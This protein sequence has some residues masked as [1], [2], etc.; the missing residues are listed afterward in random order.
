MV[1]KSGSF[2][3]FFMPTSFLSWNGP[4]KKNGLHHPNAECRRKWMKRLIGSEGS[5]LPSRIISPSLTARVRKQIYYLPLISRAET[6]VFWVEPPQLNQCH[7]YSCHSQIT[8][9]LQ[10]KDLLGAETLKHLRITCFSHSKN[11]GKRGL[12]SFSSFGSCSGGWCCCLMDK[13]TLTGPK[14][15][16][17]LGF[18]F[19]GMSYT[20]SYFKSKYWGNSFLITAWIFFT[21]FPASRIFLPAAL[22]GS[23]NSSL[24]SKQGPVRDRQHPGLGDGPCLCSTLQGRPG[25]L[26]WIETPF[27]EQD[28][29]K[30]RCIDPCSQLHHPM[31]GGCSTFN[32]I[33]A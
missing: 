26:T 13:R 10:I 6:K 24:A 33:S 1:R 3:T 27:Q 31:A 11:K 14:K 16:R 23:W 30:S 5:V 4:S 17:C 2:W 19:F 8:R 21:E 25:W 12:C 22:G 32:S 20:S 18:F 7:N 28:Q 9:F 29:G 15:K